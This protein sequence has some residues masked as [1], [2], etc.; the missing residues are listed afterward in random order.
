[1][2]PV[3]QHRWPAWRR[4]VA[5]ARRAGSP[6]RASYEPARGFDRLP[7]L[8]IHTTFADL[9]LKPAEVA[10]DAAT[11]PAGSCALWCALDVHFL[12]IPFNSIDAP[13]PTATSC[14]WS[15]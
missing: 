12:P 10:I 5:L 1:M 9:S 4:L 13:Q 14:Y 6:C 7:V 11:I 3:L 8:G 15:I 2:R